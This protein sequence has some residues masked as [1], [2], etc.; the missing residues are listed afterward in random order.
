MLEERIIDNVLNT[1]YIIDINQS[2]CLRMRFNKNTCSKCVDS[3]YARA[4]TID[5]GMNIDRN[6][7]SECMLCVSACKAGCLEIKDSDFYSLI[8]RL[9]NIQS[10][11][12]PAVL[13]CNVREGLAAHAKTFCFGY[14]S[15]EHI[16]ALL[17]FMDEPLLI[18]LTECIECRNGFIVETLKKRLESI[19]EKTSIDVFQ[20]II[21]VEN[22]AD[23]YYREIPYNRR[24]FFSALK[25]IAFQKVAGI[26]DNRDGEKGAQAYSDKK[27]PFKMEILNRI[28]A[29]SS[30]ELKEELLRNYYFD[31]ILGEDCDNCFAC[32]GICPTGALKISR[33][34]SDT[35]LLSN[36]SLCNG[37]GL[38]ENFCM[39]NSIYVKQG[40]SGYKLFEFSDMRETP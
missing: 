23:L 4:I 13:S 32:V 8:G 24:G 6:A 1:G 11:L 10:Q 2:R 31:I 27:L 36:S 39:N 29:I 3:C 14:L 25:N 20:K 37:C 9:R 7:C 18:N 33:R 30:R 21:L 5:N 26:I 34:E 28:F 16:I 15:E 17:I 12:L 38:C 22:K 19:K 35:F 40:F